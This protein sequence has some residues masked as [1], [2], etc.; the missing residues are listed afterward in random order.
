MIKNIKLITA[1]TFLAMFFLGVANSLIGSA[2]RN[3]G[4]TAAQIGLLIA[5]QN[6][7][8][9]VAVAIAGALADTRPKPG[10]LVVGSVILS[11]SFLTFYLSPQ[12]WVNLAIMLLIGAGMGTY[13]GVTDAL[14]IDLHERRAGLFININHLFVTLGSL[15]I[16]LYLIFLTLNW[17]LSVIQSGIAVLLLAAVFGLTALRSPARSHITCREKL[18]VLARERILVLLFVATV[19]IVGAE[20][21]TIGILSTFLAEVRGLATTA[22]KLGLVVH[23]VGVAVGRLIIGFVARPKQVLQY[24]LALFGLSVPCFTILFFVDLGAAFTYVAAFLAGMT[25]S[26]LLPLILTYAGSLYREMSGTVLGTIKIGI[27]L[28]GILTPFAMSLIASSLSLRAAL[29]LFPASFL[30][31][32]VLLLGVM[33][34]ERARKAGPVGRSAGASTTS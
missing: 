28:G 29:V 4:L 31:G 1:S 27:P 8:F 30:A 24:T 11:A 3:I 17:R 22:A 15:L 14:L 16:A 32:F 18:V 25:L 5:V 9:M 6:I 19:L 7:G 34:L 21:G 33:R 13:E 20:V 12:L 2:A 10:I 26:A 23:L